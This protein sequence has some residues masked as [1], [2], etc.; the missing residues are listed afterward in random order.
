VKI[1][2]DER[3]ASGRELLAALAANDVSTPS[4]DGKT[5]A[6][7]PRWWWEFHQ[8]FVAVLYWLMDVAS[9]ERA[10]D[11]WRTPRPRA[12]Y[13]HA[14]RRDRC[15]QP[16]APPVVHV[17]FQSVGAPVGTP[18]GRHL[19]SAG[20]LALRRIAGRHRNPGRRRPFACRDRA[21]GHRGRRGDRV[22]RHRARNRARCVS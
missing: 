12:V 13:L 18:A 1:D 19:D 9:L 22:P 4:E 21:S 11:R 14:D 16:E 5:A 7:S 15:R 6:G 17:A 2:P 8:A 10:A 20:G 3:Y